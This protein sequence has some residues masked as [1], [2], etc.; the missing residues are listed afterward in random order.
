MVCPWQLPHSERLWYSDPTRLDGPV[1]TTG[2]Y[3]TLTW[4][5]PAKGGRPLSLRAH[6]GRALVLTCWWRG[7]HV[8][9]TGFG[10]GPHQHT[11]AEV[12]CIKSGSMHIGSLLHTSHTSKWEPQGHRQGA[13]TAAVRQKHRNMCKAIKKTH[14]S[15]RSVSPVPPPSHTSAHP[16]HR[17]LLGGRNKGSRWGTVIWKR[18]SEEDEDR[19]R[20]FALHPSLQI[21][22]LN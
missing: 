16:F 3:P 4:D 22:L 21:L 9:P 1:W 8:P 11:G 17:R 15:Q 6:W 19:N 10:G 12:V 5:I 7:A 14:T 13:E 18:E 20:D 2:S